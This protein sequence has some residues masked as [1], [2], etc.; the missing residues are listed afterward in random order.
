MCTGRPSQLI[1]PWSGEWIPAMHLISTDFPAPL[2]PAR[3]ITLPEGTSRSTSTRAWTG[4]KFFETPRKA[5]S[6]SLP[7]PGPGPAG[8]ADPDS[9][10]VVIRPS[11]DAVVAARGRRVAGAEVGDL[12]RLVLHHGRGHVVLRD[13]GRDRVH[14]RDVGVQGRVLGRVFHEARRRRE[15]GP[16]VEGEDRR[17][18]GL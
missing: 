18:L 14:R 15:P 4:P 6:G 7:R 13:P 16:Q 9:R 3:A 2:S 5:K 10:S 1:R 17:C 11:A 12:D 8:G